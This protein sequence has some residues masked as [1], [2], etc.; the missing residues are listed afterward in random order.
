MARRNF[1]FADKVKGYLLGA[2]IV[3][4]I[5]I[6]EG[7]E[8]KECDEAGGHSHSGGV[9]YVCHGD[10]EPVRIEIRGKSNE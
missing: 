8:R 7:W 6:L 1:S 5:L 4:G 3:A 2:L 10:D 9:M